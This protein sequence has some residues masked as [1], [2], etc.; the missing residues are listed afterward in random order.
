MWHLFEKKVLIY[1]K[2]DKDTWWRIREAL[3]QGGIRRVSTGHYSN[4]P[5]APNGI[6]GMLDPRDF[7]A[8]G[9]IDRDTYYIR[10]PASEEAKAQQCI[11]SSGLVAE[12][13]SRKPEREDDTTRFD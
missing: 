1:S 6:G 12:I 7:G 2:K 4:D 11:R 10:V 8:G 9:R 13:E 3:R 5:V